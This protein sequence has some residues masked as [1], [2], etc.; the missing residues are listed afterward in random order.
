MGIGW[1]RVRLPAHIICKYQL[2]IL[3][4]SKNTMS[5]LNVRGDHLAYIEKL[6]Q[7]SIPNQKNNWKVLDLF[8]GCGGLSLGFESLSLERRQT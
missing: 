4:L 3:L 7:L 8:A 6:N 1:V 2:Y 5:S